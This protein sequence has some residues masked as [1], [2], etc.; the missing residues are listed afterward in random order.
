MPLDQE[1]FLANA[2]RA[3]AETTARVLRPPPK[4]DYVKWAIDNVVLG[5]ES[6]RPGRYDPNY[7]PW[8]RYVLE[9]LAP[10]HPAREVIDMGSAQRGKT[11][12]QQIFIGGSLDL[13]PGPFLVYHPTEPN[14]ISWARQKWKAFV[15]GTTAL[16]RL[17]PLGRTRGAANSVLL[18]E[19]RDGLGVLEIN[20][21]GS[22]SALS[23]RSSPRQ[24]HDDLSKW[25]NNQ[26]GDSEAQADNRSRAFRWN[27][28]ILKSGTPLVEPGC[29]VT[30]K[31]KQSTQGE[32]HL[33]C[34]HCG[35][36]APLTWDNFRAS[37]DAIKDARKSGAPEPPPHFTCGSCKG[38]ILEK[39]RHGMLKTIKLVFKNFEEGARRG[40]WGFYVWAVYVPSESWKTICEAWLSA[41][42]DPHAEQTFYN[43]TLGLAYFV[44]GEAP[45]WQ[46][47]RE[48]A[49]AAVHLRLGRIPV[50]GIILTIGADCQSDRV[51]VHVKAFGRDGRR[52]T[53]E[54]IVIDG[55]ISEDKAQA[56][57]DALLTKTWPDEFGKRRPV[58]MLAIDGNYAT[59][60]VLDWAKGHPE[61]RV[62]VVRGIRGDA[63]PAM[64]LV[65]RLKTAS[66]EV[67]KFQ[68][69]FWNVGVSALKAALYK[70]LFKADPLLKGF[71]GYPPGL[72]EEF[73]KQLCAER[74]VP[75]KVRGGTEWRW[76]RAEGQPNEV[77]DTE[78]YAEAAARRLGWKRFTDA[79]WDKLT[80]DRETQPA[81][82]QLDFDDLDLAQKTQRPAREFRTANLE[83]AAHA[84][85]D[86]AE[87]LEAPQNGPTERSGLRRRGY[88]RN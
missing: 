51:E 76:E 25:E 14:A 79:D 49:E 10:D 5:K 66:G 63:A 35:V 36:H 1:N 22:P 2:E 21:A 75:V 70:A 27:A 29:R 44:Q 37:C 3:A 72:N 58:D 30:R 4:V 17:F 32:F 52:W 64:T 67:I 62:I 7:H 6:P 45:E 48:R 12:I 84:V 86:G 55:H 47:I 87:Q 78:M 13:D 71:C 46:K 85:R 23:Q 42:G 28:K 65:K 15:R 77:L 73:Y 8:D 69:R 11:F 24:V 83:N 43:D 54:Y 68:R 40:I 56:A 9:A 88:L 38:V 16:L 34:P 60:D 41:E 53:V 31:W 81:E 20:G 50:G 26:A 80:A 19:R 61:D 33:A 82:R 18:Q 39:H 74:R 57:L 59:E